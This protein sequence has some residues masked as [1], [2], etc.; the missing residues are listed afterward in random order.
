MSKRADPDLEI[1]RRWSE[2]P[3]DRGVVRS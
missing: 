1:Y 3:W 2:R